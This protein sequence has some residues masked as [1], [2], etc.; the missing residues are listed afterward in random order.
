MQIST[1]DVCQKMNRKL[2][3][4]T[5]KLHPIA[6]KEPWYMIGI[7]LLHLL[8]LTISDYMTRW[9]EALPTKDK[10]A[11]TVATALFKVIQ[12]VN[13]VCIRQYT[14]YCETAVLS[15]ML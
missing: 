2:T 3:T 13:S 6:V 4:G 10:N 9:V 5:P 1:C 11:S 8:H 15:C 12:V 14:S 7:V